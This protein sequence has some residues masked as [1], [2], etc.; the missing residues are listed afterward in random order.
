MTGNGQEAWP[1]TETNSQG[2]SVDSSIRSA[3]K[4]SVRNTM[5]ILCV[6]HCDQWVFLTDVGAW[7]RLLMNVFGNA[8]KYTQSGSILVQL[9]T[10]MVPITGRVESRKYRLTLTVSDTGRGI[11]SN[12]IQNHLFKPFRQ[13][14]DLDVGAGLGLSIVSSIAKSLGATVNIQSDVGL[15][16]KISITANLESSLPLPGAETRFQTRIDRARAFTS[17]KEVCLVGFDLLPA[18][19]EDVGSELST[20]SRQLIQ[21]KIALENT[22]SQWLGMSITMSRSP[23]ESL[24]CIVVIHES[25]LSRWLQSEGKKCTEGYRQRQPWVILGLHSSVE[26]GSGLNLHYLQHP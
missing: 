5:I 25:Y 1:N 17:G 16:T 15:G 18:M 8:L 20:Q 19:S 7:K 3:T 23:E 12:Y 6:D 11:S 22:L 13:E 4:A 9:K 26:E 14:N 10:T 2:T 21:L 24:A